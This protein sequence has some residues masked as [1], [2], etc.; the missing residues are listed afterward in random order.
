MLCLQWLPCL[1]FWQRNKDL[2]ECEKK[3]KVKSN[4]ALISDQVLEVPNSFP[5]IIKKPLSFQSSPNICSKIALKTTF[6]AP[7][8][9]ANVHCVSKGLQK[10]FPPPCSV[11]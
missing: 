11:L 10:V 9:L 3:R 1:F 4:N 2:A 6:G 5:F 7:T 8:V